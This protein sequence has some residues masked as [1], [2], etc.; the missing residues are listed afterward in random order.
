MTNEYT[1]GTVHRYLAPWYLVWY[2][3]NYF[4]RS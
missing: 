2:R 4:I 1:T 3:R